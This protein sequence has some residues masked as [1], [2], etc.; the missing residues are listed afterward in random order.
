M[1][2]RVGDAVFSPFHRLLCLA[3]GVDVGHQ[4]YPPRLLHWRGHSFAYCVSDSDLWRR[5]A[6]LCRVD[7]CVLFA[8]RCDE[9]DGAAFGVRS[10]PL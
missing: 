8:V 2:W 10:C 5:R 3:D 7:D 6:V 9:F 1:D 4:I